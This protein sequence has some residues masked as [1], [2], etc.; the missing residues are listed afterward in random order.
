MLLLRASR[1]SQL[2][3]LSDSLLAVLLHE[4]RHDSLELLRSVR[5][6]P[7]RDINFLAGRERDGMEKLAALDTSGH[8]GHALQVQIADRLHGKI[9]SEAL[10]EAVVKING[11][12]ASSLELADGQAACVWHYLRRQVAGLEGAVFFDV[13][14]CSPTHQRAE[15]HGLR[16]NRNGSRHLVRWRL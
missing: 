7:M 6:L 4:I 1:L 14:A 8:E 9:G 10:E 12:G 2:R 5:P 15:T 11:N 16:R 13:M 3:F